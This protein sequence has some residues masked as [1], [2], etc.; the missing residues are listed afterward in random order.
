MSVSAA[1]V[2]DGKVVNGCCQILT[3]YV[4]TSKPVDSKPVDSMSTRPEHH[5]HPD[6]APH[7]TIALLPIPPCSRHRTTDLTTN[8]NAGLIVPDEHK[9]P[10]IDPLPALPA[11][12]T[13]MWYWCMCN[14]RILI[15]SKHF[16]M[17]RPYH[18]LRIDLV[19]SK[20]GTTWRCNVLRHQR[21]SPRLS[22]DT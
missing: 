19:R 4:F 8:S 5:S 12:S 9:T 21:P 1:G 11:D 13:P 6:W 15:Y 2:T 20:F 17:A 14:L 7:R 22:N 16:R 18:M 3:T 10:H